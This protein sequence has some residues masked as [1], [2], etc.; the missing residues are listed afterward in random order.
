MVCWRA[1]QADASKLASLRRTVHPTPFADP[2]FD[3]HP[4][5]FNA[6]GTPGP[7]IA[8][9]I[10]EVSTA[11]ARRSGAPFHRLRRILRHTLF[12]VWATVAQSFLI[13]DPAW[14]RAAGYAACV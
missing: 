7:E 11:I 2:Y 5:A 3:F 8:L 6:H 1:S 10:R 9:Y 14:I 4:L 12:A 13:R